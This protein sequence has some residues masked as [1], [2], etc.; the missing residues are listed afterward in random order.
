MPAPATLASTVT[1][2]TAQML[3]VGFRAARKAPRAAPVSA[4]TGGKTFSSAASAP[5]PR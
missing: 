1:R 2:Y 3:I 5:M 4:G